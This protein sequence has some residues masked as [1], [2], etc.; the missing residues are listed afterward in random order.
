MIKYRIFILTFLSLS[1][2]ITLFPPFEFGD[3]YLE[4]KGERRQSFMVIDDLPIKKYDFLFA[5]N[6]KYF[7]IGSYRLERKFYINEKFNIDTTDAFSIMVQNGVDTFFINKYKVSGKDWYDDIPP[8][9][10]VLNLN[11]SPEVYRTRKLIT[12]KGLQKLIDL[13]KRLDYAEREENL[14]LEKKRYNE[15]RIKTGIDDTVQHYKVYKV[16]KPYWYL[17]KRGMQIDE[18]IMEYILAAI[19]GLLFQIFFKNNSKKS[20]L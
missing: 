7:S 20:L 2:P 4:T 1:I 8:K 17:L 6:K 3:Q 18:L 9:K 11:T 16:N 5:S 13:G 14:A 19:V 10:S 15:A 12:G